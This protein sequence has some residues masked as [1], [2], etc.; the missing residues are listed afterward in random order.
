MHFEILLDFHTLL[1]YNNGEPNGS[2]EGVSPPV[3]EVRCVKEGV[4]PPIFKVRGV[5]DVGGHFVLPLFQKEDRE[6]EATYQN[7]GFY[8]VDLEYLRYLHKLDSEVQFSESKNYAEKPFLGIVVILGDRHYVIPLTSAKPK[9]TKL[10]YVEQGHYLIYEQ[11]PKEE[12]RPKDIYKE[13]SDTEV[14]KLFSM[15]EIKKMIPVKLE[16]CERIDFSDLADR[17]YADLLEKEYRFCRKI[18]DGILDKA[19]R[20]YEDQ[21]RTGRVRPMCCDYSKLEAACDAY[22]REEKAPASV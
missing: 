22:F 12:L 21:K 18:Q 4:S 5:N 2:P 16:L 15:L 8:H 3:F 20:L 7:F 6:M 17:R 19:K 11:I 13:I 9:H 14:R 1:A 10:R